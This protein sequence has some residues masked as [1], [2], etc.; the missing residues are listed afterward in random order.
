M[1]KT[2]FEKIKEFVVAMLAIE[3]IEDDDYAH[4]FSVALNNDPEF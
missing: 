3:G 1:D 4:R 2:K